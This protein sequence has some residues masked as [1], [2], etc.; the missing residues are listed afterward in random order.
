M[1]YSIN[2]NAGAL[3]ALQNLTSTQTALAKTQNIISTGKMV[4]S[5]ADNGAVWSIANTMGG[6]VGDLDAVKDS[7]NRATSTIDVA[8]SASTRFE[9]PVFSES[10]SLLTKESWPARAF[11]PVPSDVRALF[12]FVM[13]EVRVAT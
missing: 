5:A 11:E 2:T 13:S 3:I 1:T 8:M 7:L 9:M 10:C 4:N 12:T 6:K